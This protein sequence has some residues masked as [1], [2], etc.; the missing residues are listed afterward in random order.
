MTQILR[1]A[2]EIDRH[3]DELCGSSRGD[4]RPE[5]LRTPESRRA[6]VEQVEA[7]FG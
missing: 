7:S 5:A 4:E 6:A 3:E 2:E 1:E